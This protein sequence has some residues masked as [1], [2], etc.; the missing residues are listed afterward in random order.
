[1][2]TKLK[3]CLLFPKRIANYIGEKKWKTWGFFLFLTLL[4]FIPYLIICLTTISIPSTITENI[5]DSFEQKTINYSISDG[6]LHTTMSSPQT[7]YVESTIDLEGTTIPVVFIFSM[8]ESNSN[9]INSLTAE[10]GYVY[11]VIFNQNKISLGMGI[12]D[13]SLDPSQVDQATSIIKLSNNVQEGIL[14]SFMDLDYS[15]FDNVNINF[16]D[17]ATNSVLF[18]QTFNLLFEKMFNSIKMNLLPYLIIIF[19]IS[20][21]LDI[22][23]SCL[24]IAILLKLFFRLGNLKF[25]TFYQTAVLCSLPYVLINCVSVLTS[26]D[27]LSLLS[28]LIIVL[29]TFKSLTAY[30]MLG[31]DSNNKNVSPEVRIMPGVYVH[32]EETNE[33]VKNNNDNEH[34]DEKRYYDQEESKG[35]DDSNEL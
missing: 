16:A 27:F 22:A 8:E 14:V 1:M 10:D 9:I 33:D 28:D 11:A 31:G 32:K 13:T 25:K 2:Y 26:W 4:T 23:F 29:Y 21:A 17:I 7:Q 12:K 24:F 34:N 5:I 20:S 19:L 30:V 3:D 35:D 6:E 18:E 15:D